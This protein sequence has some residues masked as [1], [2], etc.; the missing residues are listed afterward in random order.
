MNPEDQ[1]IQYNHNILLQFFT[2]IYIDKIPFPW[3]S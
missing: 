2:G 3:Y 1:I